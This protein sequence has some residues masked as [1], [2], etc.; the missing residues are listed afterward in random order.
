MLSVLLATG[1]EFA[2]RI[3]Y[4][5]EEPFMRL[6]SRRRF[7]LNTST[8]AGSLLFLR[9]LSQAQS[10]DAEPGGLTLW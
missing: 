1:I 8:V 10:V 7:L 5:E 6:F 2:N 4:C 3:V 9:R